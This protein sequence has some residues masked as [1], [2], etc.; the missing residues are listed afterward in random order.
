MDCSL[1]N[2]SREVE[3]AHLTNL[4]FMSDLA[5]AQAHRS[6]YKVTSRYHHSIL[7]F[8]PGIQTS[9][10]PN[11]TLVLNLS[12][13]LNLYLSTHQ[14]HVSTQLP[15]ITED[16]ITKGEFLLFILNS[17]WGGQ[18]HPYFALSALFI[19][20]IPSLYVLRNGSVGIVSMIRKY[21]GRK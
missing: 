3:F 1:L 6:G 21:L 9:T 17:S 13:P 5:R 14:R 18:R 20:V 7:F 10:S 15:S 12:I 16:A 8:L 19:G 4:N 11:R 2:S